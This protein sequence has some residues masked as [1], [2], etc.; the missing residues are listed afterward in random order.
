MYY[1]NV[2]INVYNK[3][4]M[5]IELIRNRN[6]MQ[7]DYYKEIISNYRECV[8]EIDMSMLADYLKKFTNE[9][10]IFEVMQREVF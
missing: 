4:R 9:K 10:N 1:N 5:L 6:L 8:D 7:F 3:E 2:K